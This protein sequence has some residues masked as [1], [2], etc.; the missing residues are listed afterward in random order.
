P[1]G[2]GQKDGQQA[3]KRPARAGN[4]KP[5]VVIEPRVVSSALRLPFANA[6]HTQSQVS[7]FMVIVRA[8]GHAGYGEGLPLAYR[9]E[10]VAEVMAAFASYRDGLMTAVQAGLPSPDAADQILAEL[11]CTGAVRAATSAA[12]HDLHGKLAG[13]PTWQ[14]L[15][16]PRTGPPTCWT[17]PLGAP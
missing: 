15:G 5:D 14:L 4:R 16:L 2:A 10:S 3:P 8:A 12:V 13:R 1:E 6:R 7:H 9:N 17:I 11:P